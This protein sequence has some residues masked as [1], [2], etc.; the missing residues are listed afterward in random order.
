MFNVTIVSILIPIY[1][2]K[3]SLG[4]APGI[5]PMFVKIPLSLIDENTIVF[6]KLKSPDVADRTLV[7]IGN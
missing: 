2:I 6:E 7:S 5:V 1:V 3:P 4:I